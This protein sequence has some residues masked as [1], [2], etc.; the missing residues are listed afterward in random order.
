MPIP[1]ITEEEFVRLEDDDDV[2]SEIEMP[3]K[4]KETASGGCGENREEE[5]KSND[6]KNKRQSLRVIEKRK[7]SSFDQTNQDI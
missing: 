1:V 7:G 3:M 6:V 4:R 2:P 5:S